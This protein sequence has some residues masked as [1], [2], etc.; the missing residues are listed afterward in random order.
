MQQIHDSMS[1]LVCLQDQPKP[2]RYGKRGEARLGLIFVPIGSGGLW[3]HGWLGWFGARLWSVVKAGMSVSCTCKL[4]AARPTGE[5]K[6]RVPKVE[7]AVVGWSGILDHE[8]DD[9]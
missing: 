8:I 5:A 3:M 7:G 6:R 4:R 1:I 9:K 2:L